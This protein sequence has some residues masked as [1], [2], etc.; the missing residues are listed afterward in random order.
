MTSWLIQSELNPEC[1]VLTEHGEMQHTSLQTDVREGREKLFLDFKRRW[2]IDLDES[3][4]EDYIV[5]TMLDPR[6]KNWD[7][8]GATI[9]SNYTMTRDKALRLLRAAWKA[10]WKPTVTVRLQS[11]TTATANPSKSNFGEA[12]FMRRKSA[13]PICDAAPVDQD[14]LDLYLSLPQEMNVDTFDVMVW[15]NA[16]AHELPDVYRMAR[17]FLGCPATTAGVERA[18]SAAGRMHDDLKKSTGEDTIEHM[19]WVKMGP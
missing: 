16:K 3:I 18:F 10:D 19:L 9:Y 14:Q 2:V 12:G 7:F 13:E 6:W 15:W 1:P 4:L 17:Q 5:A 8:E 11:A